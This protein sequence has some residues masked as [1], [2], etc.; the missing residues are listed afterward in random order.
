[1]Y[2][3]FSLFFFLSSL[4]P[5]LFQVTLVFGH[6]GNVKE[7]LFFLICTGR[8]FSFCLPYKKKTIFFRDIACLPILQNQLME[9]LIFICS[10]LSLLIQV[11]HIVFMFLQDKYLLFF[12]TKPNDFI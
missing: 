7:I 3:Y 6:F 9:F 2:S 8:L 12:L 4:L 10:I 11:Y 1:M 5:F